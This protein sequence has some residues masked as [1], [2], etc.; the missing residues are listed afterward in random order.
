MVEEV[1]RHYHLDGPALKLRPMN[2]PHQARLK[3]IRDQLDIPW[4]DV[5][6][7]LWNPPF[8]FIVLV[9]RKIQQ[10]NACGVL[11][12][13]HRTAQHWFGRLK[14]IADEVLTLEDSAHVMMKGTNVNP[15]WLLALATFGLGRSGHRGFA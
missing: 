14:S 1:Y 8:D 13:P 15:A 3:V 5:R 7:R 11:V 2:E 4:T 10:E 6:D 12:S 9:V